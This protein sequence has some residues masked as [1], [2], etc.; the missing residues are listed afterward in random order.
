MNQDEVLKLALE[1]GLILKTT[2]LDLCPSY[3]TKL[4]EFANAIQS[5]SGEAE[6]VAWVRMRNGKIDWD[7]NCLGSQSGDVL[8]RYEDN[9]EY[10]EQPL[11]TYQPD[12]SARIKTLED[13]IT[14]LVK[15]RDERTTKYIGMAHDNKELTA[16]N[17]KLVEALEKIAFMGTD[18]A[19]GTDREYFMQ[20]QLGHCIGIAAETLAL[21]K[22]G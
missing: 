17:A 14:K 11:F 1:H 16:T 10:T 13:E 4:Q 15:V 20:R 2:N 8:Y 18:N 5:H 3:L 12:Q 6:P 22:E 9:D 21:T 7:E 19:L